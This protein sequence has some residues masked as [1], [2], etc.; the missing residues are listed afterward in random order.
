MRYEGFGGAIEGAGYAWQT[1]DDCVREQDL[2]YRPKDD[3]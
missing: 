2:G 3:G 1:W